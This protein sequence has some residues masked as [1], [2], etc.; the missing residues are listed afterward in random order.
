MIMSTP[1][2]SA[3]LVFHSTQFDIV[4]RNGL[5]WLRGLQVASALG[6][7]NPAA[8]IQNLYT[9]NADEFTPSMTAVV[10]LPSAGG[11]QET[12]I[13]SLR[14]AHL[15]GMFARTPV[16][17]EFRH[18]VLDILDRQT[19]PATSAAPELPLIAEDPQE[20]FEQRR[21]KMTDNWN[22][23]K[24]NQDGRGLSPLYLAFLAMLDGNKTDA[25]LLLLL[26]EMHQAHDGFRDISACD[27]I[28]ESRGHLSSKSAIDRSRERLIKS[29][30][31]QELPYR[32]W[33][34][35]T[36]TLC[37]ALD[38]VAGNQAPIA[39][40]LARFKTTTKASP[41]AVPVL[42]APWNPDDFSTVH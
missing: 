3:P 36:G 40:Y 2:A 32:M 10:K 25:C 17:A 21:Q 20:I 12:R 26:S 38:A 13:F 29:G 7:K 16:A 28:A 4:D 34:I 41:T 30:F 5:P 14:G 27:L 6:Y 31:L 23:I 15:L 1:G 42:T 19:V 33:R 24:I 37:T 9:R 8:D 18:W 11:E 39:D 35:N 22:K